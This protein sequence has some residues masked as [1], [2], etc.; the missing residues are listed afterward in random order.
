M[1]PDKAGSVRG[2][3]QFARVGKRKR[4][5]ETRMGINQNERRVLLGRNLLFSGSEPGKARWLVEVAS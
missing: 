4:R 5:L 1:A 2:S 3:V